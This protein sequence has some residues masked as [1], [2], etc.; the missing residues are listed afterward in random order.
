M[1]R[2]KRTVIAA[3]VLLILG[4]ASFVAMPII[5][6]AYINDSTG[7]LKGHRVWLG[8]WETAHWSK[9]SDLERFMRE[10][11]P[12]DLQQRWTNYSGKGKNIWGAYLLFGHDRPVPLGQIGYDNLN[13]YDSKLT[14]EDKGKFY[15]IFADPD[16]TVAGALSNCIA[17]PFL[18]GFGSDMQPAF[19]LQLAVAMVEEAQRCDMGSVDEQRR[20]LRYV[21][22]LQWVEPPVVAEAYRLAMRNLETKDPFRLA[23]SEKTLFLINDVYYVGPVSKKDVPDLLKNYFPM[24]H[25]PIA[26]EEFLQWSDRYP[27]RNLAPVIEA[28]E[29]SAHD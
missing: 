25:S 20:F 12:H 5:D 29:V 26:V 14:D 10:K 27:K 23:D 9:E 2:T 3:I 4:I 28:L 18:F 15:E 7:S 21:E 13:S 24:G 1:K 8:L 6:Y 22:A 19:H 11:N 16:R 17:W